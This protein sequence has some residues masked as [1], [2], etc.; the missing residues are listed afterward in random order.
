MTVT[1]AQKSLIKETIRETFL[2]MGVDITDHEEIVRYQQDRHFLRAAR[3]RAE[4]T[5]NKAW[6]YGIGVI[7][8]GFGAALLLGIAHMLGLRS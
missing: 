7:L 1:S 4:G 6:D 5:G 3:L 2:S 8:S